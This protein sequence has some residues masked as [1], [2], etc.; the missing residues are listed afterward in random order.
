MRTRMPGGVAG[1]QKDE[2]AAPYA[3]STL[4]PKIRWQMPSLTL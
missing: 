4:H 3:D 2:A 1:E